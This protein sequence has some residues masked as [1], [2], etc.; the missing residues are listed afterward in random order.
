[1]PMLENFSKQVRE[2][3]RR[4]YGR[5]PSAA[6][7]SIQFNRL[8]DKNRQVSGESVRRWMRGQTMPNQHHIQVLATWLGLDINETLGLG[9]SPE[10]LPCCKRPSEYSKEVLI[11]AELIDQLPSVMQTRMTNFILSLKVK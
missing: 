6:F 3:L 1:M 5:L 11:L 4:K 2:S 9:R 7:V 10:T 8:V